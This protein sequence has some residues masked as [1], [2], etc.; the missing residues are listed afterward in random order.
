MKQKTR[1][2][3]SHLLVT[4]FESLPNA[5]VAAAYILMCIYV[6]AFQHHFKYNI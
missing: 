4:L 5:Y 3:Y 1:L 6:H 2:I